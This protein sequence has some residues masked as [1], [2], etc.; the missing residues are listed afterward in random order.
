MEKYYVGDTNRV[1]IKC[2]N[3][4]LEKK[5]NVLKFKD[6]HKRLKVKCKCGEVFRFTLDFRGYYR[7]NVRF[8]GEYFAKGKSGE[9]IIED[10]S[11]NGINFRTTKPHDFSKDDLAE[12]IFTLD[13]PVGMEIRTRVKIIWINDRSV[14]VQFMNP[15]LL[16]RD[17]GVYLIK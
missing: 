3:C 13:N 10:I 15:N 6:T 1:K 9:I 4:G 2:P 16:E 14:G 12:L 17:L 11:K 7:K 5:I 8:T